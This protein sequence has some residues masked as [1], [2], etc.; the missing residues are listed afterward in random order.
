MTFSATSAGGRLALKLAV[1]ALVQWTMVG[2][3]IG[4]IY[5]PAA[6]R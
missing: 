4:T 2:I 3:V 5:K 1:S 6:G